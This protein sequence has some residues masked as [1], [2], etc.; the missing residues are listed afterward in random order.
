MLPGM[1][2]NRVVPA[3]D[4]RRAFMVVAGNTEQSWVDPTDPLRLEFEY[5]Q[6]IAEVLDATVLARPDG[7]RVRIVHVGGGGLTLPRFVAARRPHTAQIVLEPDEKLTEEVRARLPLP[8]NS[9]IKVRPL[10]GRSGV[11]QLP[12]AY[13]DALIVDA[14]A[15]ASV[16]ADLATVEFFVD[17]RRALRPGG[18]LLMNLTDQA[19]FAWSKRCLAALCVTQPQLAVSAEVPVWK[20]RRFGNLVAVAGPD[21]PLTDL[22]RVLARAAFPYRLLAGR[23]LARFV[24]ASVP[25]TEADAEPSPPPAWSRTWFS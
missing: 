15:A 8:R 18:L 4:D 2:T 23:D 21:L 24:G 7:E 3:P 17:A 11:A 25:F 16:P 20:G 5:V 10:D 6:R 1:V 22:T 19:P 13:A 14:F 12:D 9:G